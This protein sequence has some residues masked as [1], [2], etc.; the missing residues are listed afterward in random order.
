MTID[1]NKW[2]EDNRAVLET[3]PDHHVALDLSEGKILFNT[4]K[5]WLFEEWLTFHNSR[6]GTAEVHA[7]HVPTV[8]RPRPVPV[9]G[10][11][12]SLW[13][14][15]VY[16]KTAGALFTVTLIAAD[17]EQARKMALE[18]IG[19]PKMDTE[20]P[21]EIGP[22]TEPCVITSRSGMRKEFQR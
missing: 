19:I 5:E 7:F 20:E 22:V 18:H 2:I 11:P 12:L 8:L 10:K 3:I 1:V 21:R 14:V 4:A 6:E 16:R 9:A 13:E 15:G 17:A